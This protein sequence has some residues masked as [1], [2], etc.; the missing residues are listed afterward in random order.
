MFYRRKIILA[1]FQLFDGQLEKIRLQKFII[2][3]LVNVS[4]KL[5]MIL[6]LIN[7]VAIP[8]QRTLI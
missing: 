6:S 4:K 5:N 2:P 8:I 3:F 1:L 7:M